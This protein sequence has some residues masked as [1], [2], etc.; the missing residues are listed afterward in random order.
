MS[1][2]RL[3]HGFE[4]STTFKNGQKILVPNSKL[5]V[6]SPIIRTNAAEYR[7]IK[8]LLISVPDGPLPS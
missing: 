5:R 4:Y 2:P 6:N 1:K 3:N 7:A 8:P